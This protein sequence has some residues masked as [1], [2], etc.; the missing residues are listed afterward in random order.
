MI[1]NDSRWWWR[2]RRRQEEEE[3]D[4]KTFIC[5]FKI[6]AES[7]VGQ[8]V[9]KFHTT[10]TLWSE[11]ASTK[12]L[13]PTIGISNYMGS[14][15]QNVKNWLNCPAYHDEQSWAKDHHFP[16]PKWRAKGRNWVH[17]PE[18]NLIQAYSQSYSIVFQWFGGTLLF[19]QLF[20]KMSALPM[21]DHFSRLQRALTKFEI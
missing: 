19:H 15:K 6:C 20:G 5:K 16:N 4:D 2:Q 17:F 18:N 11:H 7:M 21:F 1:N 10:V 8:P 13:A 3:E 12:R 9:F 14:L